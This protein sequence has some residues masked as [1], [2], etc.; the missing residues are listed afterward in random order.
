M[1]GSEPEPERCCQ[2]VSDIVQQSRV[3]VEHVT[4][5]PTQHVEMHPLARLTKVIRRRA[6]REVNVSDQSQLD[7][8]LQRSEHR[9]TMHIGNEV[10][11][12]AD[13]LV[14]RQMSVG[15]S[16]HLQ[17]SAAGRGHLLIQR[18]Q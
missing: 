17:H 18:T 15:R 4:T 12:P 13:D 11:D 8:P 10:G 5:R 1:I 2:S 6:M 7:Q 14:R 3:G 9:C 16:H